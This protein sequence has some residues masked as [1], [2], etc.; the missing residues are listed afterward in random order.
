MGLAMPVQRKIFRIEEMIG[1]RPRETAP[2][3]QADA[4]PRDTEML[5]EIAKLRALLAPRDESRMLKAEIDIIEQAIQQTKREI[6]LLS[7]HGIDGAAMTRV[8]HELDAV[9]SGTE[10]ATLRILKATE[11]IEQTANSLAAALKSDHEQG[12]AEDIQDRATSIFEACNFQDL[13]GQRITKV[14]TTL[15][16]IEDHIGRMAE[17]W[18]EIE[19]HQNTEP[20]R[21]PLRAEEKLLNG[22]KLPDDPGHSSQAEIDAMFAGGLGVTTAA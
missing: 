8:A 1:V 6:A 17:I 7:E 4:G 21:A 12:M 10:Q 22:P 18:R 3:P 13:T 20:S 2:A 11:D 15:K 19:K 16:L 14:V 5:A 9:V